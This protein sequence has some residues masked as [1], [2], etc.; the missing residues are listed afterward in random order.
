MNP[1]EKARIESLSPLLQAKEIGRIETGIEA[2]KIQTKKTTAAPPPPKIVNANAHPVTDES[3]MS[4]AEWFKREDDR[5][6]A[7]LKRR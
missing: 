4:D 1:K 6:K 5:K 7:A 3:K 2:G